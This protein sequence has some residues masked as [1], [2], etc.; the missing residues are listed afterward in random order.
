MQIFIRCLVTSRR[1]AS[2][3]VTISV[4]SLSLRGRNMQALREDSHLPAAGWSNWKK[5]MVPNRP[6]DD[7]Q[8]LQARN[9]SGSIWRNIGNALSDYGRHCGIYEWQARQAGQPNRVVYVG[10][11]CRSKPGALIGR[12]RKYCTNGS[13]KDVLID[14][15]LTRGYELWVRVKP[16]GVGQKAA[17]EVAENAL[18]AQ[19]D[20]AWNIRNNPAVRAVLP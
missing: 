1:R 13:H 7:P 14:D 10:S 20:Y 3:R 18:L 5:A 12:I 8:H 9:G 17:A 19:Y 15:A 2:L 6:E 4:G 16:I 11:T